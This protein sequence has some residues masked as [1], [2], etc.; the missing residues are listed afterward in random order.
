MQ[1]YAGS[2]GFSYKEWK[3]SF[4]PEKLPPAQMLE[5]YAE[6]LASVEI[7]NTFYRLPRPQMLE[8]WASKVP[9]GFRFA[10]KATRRIT[11]SKKL[12]DCDDEMKFFVDALQ[13]LGS[14]LGPVLFQLPPN[15]SIDLPRLEAFLPLIPAPMRA[16]F[17]FRH[18]SWLT[19]EVAD[20]L[21]A[22]NHTLVW[23][24]TDKTASHEWP[25]SGDWFYLRLRRAGY[26]EAQLRGW[27]QRLRA[28]KAQKAF[29][30]FKHEDEG[31][32][33]A[34]AQKLTELAADAG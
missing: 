7:N 18:D 28:A 32:A 27:L 24:D 33:P 5:F 10:I 12:K 21:A 6:R 20:G 30:F 29:V 8:G 4:Y 15:F 31:A 9:A 3:G 26:D 17:E 23:G 13:S 11:H 14:R 19:R 34:L 16:A 1:L 2:S 25:T 22:C